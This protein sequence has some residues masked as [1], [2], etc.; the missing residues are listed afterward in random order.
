M[1]AVKGHQEEEEEEEDETGIVKKDAT[2]SSSN[3]KGL[4]NFT[5]VF[6]FS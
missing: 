6:Y 1:K 4:L 5:P 2:P 3:T